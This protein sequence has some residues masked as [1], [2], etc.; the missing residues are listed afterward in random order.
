MG[1][2]AVQAVQE[3]A[4][5][6]ARKWKPGEAVAGADAKKPR[7]PTGKIQCRKFFLHADIRRDNMSVGCSA[8]TVSFRPLPG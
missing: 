2:G 1:W 3:K 7:R 8:M 5:E 6:K 4:T